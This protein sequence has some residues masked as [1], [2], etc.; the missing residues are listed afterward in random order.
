[1]MINVT[2]TKMMRQWYGMKRL[3]HCVPGCNVLY[4]DDPCCWYYNQW[5]YRVCFHW[6]SCWNGGGV[7][8]GYYFDSSFHYYQYCR[9]T[10]HEIRHLFEEMIDRAFLPGIGMENKQECFSSSSVKFKSIDGFCS[11][12]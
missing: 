9:C 4:D 12:C 1:M 7:V 3:I 6:I 5:Y 10:Y 11:S 2:L 8:S